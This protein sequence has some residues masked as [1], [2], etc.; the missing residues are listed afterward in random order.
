MTQAQREARKEARRAARE[1]G[2]GAVYNILHTRASADLIGWC[3]MRA[4][5]YA[6][7]YLNSKTAGNGTN[8]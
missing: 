6:N 2:E 4:A 7:V 3:A 5:H 8:G 1:M